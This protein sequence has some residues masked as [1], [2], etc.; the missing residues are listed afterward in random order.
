[1]KNVG[2]WMLDAFPFKLNCV[3]KTIV[4]WRIV[5]VSFGRKF[6][7]VFLGIHAIEN[8]I[9]ATLFIVYK[10]RTSYHTCMVDLALEKRMKSFS[11]DWGASTLEFTKE[12]SV[13]KD[14]ACVCLKNLKITQPTQ[15]WCYRSFTSKRKQLQLYFGATWWW[16]DLVKLQKS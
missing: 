13:W 12:H 3:F 4:R 14:K 1:M 9:R 15:N 2:Y 7:I 6:K 5:H 8:S 10:I 11:P 16:E